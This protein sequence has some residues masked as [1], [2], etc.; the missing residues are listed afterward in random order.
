MPA[1][2]TFRIERSAVIDA[3]PET[4]FALVEDFHRWTEWSPW[5]KLD[6]DLKRTYSGAAH[7]VGAAYAWEGKKA[8]SGRM[9]ITTA[10]RASR[11]VIK[12][13]FI[14]PFTAHNT[15]EFSFAREGHGTRVTWAMT[16]PVTLLSK[17]MGLF[18]STEKFVG[19]QFEEGLANMK[20][21]A[22]AETA[23]A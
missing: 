12:L 9:E 14:K 5:E 18:V 17:V 4:T 23:T 10:E 21:V 19:P 11:I 20:R 15:A 8:G 2:E 3:P 7:G 16:V 13:D 1:N 6:A 22:E